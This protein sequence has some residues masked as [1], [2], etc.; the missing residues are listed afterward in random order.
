[1]YYNEVAFNPKE[2]GWPGGIFPQTVGKVLGDATKFW[3][4]TGIYHNCNTY[5]VSHGWKGCGVG[6]KSEEN[7]RGYR[8]RYWFIFDSSALLVSRTDEAA[9]QN[10]LYNGQKKKFALTLQYLKTPYCILLH[11]IAYSTFYTVLWRG[12]GNI[13]F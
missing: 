4:I 13:A 6:T 7:Y 1:M 9:I 12:V 3:Q 2:V 5:D 11:I 8:Q 10:D